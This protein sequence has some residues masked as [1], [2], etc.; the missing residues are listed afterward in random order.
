MTVLASQLYMFM[1]FLMFIAFI[2]LRN[3]SNYLFKI[4]GGD[5]IRIIVAGFGITGCFMTIL[6]G[7]IPFKDNLDLMYYGF[8]IFYI[9]TLIV[10]LPQIFN[11]KKQKQI[12]YE[13]QFYFLRN[14]SNLD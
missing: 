8:T 3:Q 9:L 12:V 5:T 10:L 2:K 6:V 13:S 1:Y 4:P 7:F 11:F 14:L